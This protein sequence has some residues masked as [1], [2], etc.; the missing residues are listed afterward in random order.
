MI[1]LKN[2]AVE[3]QSRLHFRNIIEKLYPKR[4]VVDSTIIFDICKQSELPTPV[5]E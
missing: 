2:A 3:T 1:F 4:N 5:S